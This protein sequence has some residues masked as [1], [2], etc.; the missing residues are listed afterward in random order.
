MEAIHLANRFDEWLGS[1]NPTDKFFVQISFRSVHKPF[2]ASPDLR[3]ACINNEV[4]NDLG[5]AKTSLEL[6]YGGCVHSI[7]QA[8]GLIRA[9]L[10]ARRPDDYANTMLIFTSDN[11]PEAG[12]KGGAGST[13]GMKGRKLSMFEGLL[14]IP[15][16]M[17]WPSVIRQN[18]K[19]GGL[20]SIMD[21][22]QTFS[23]ALRRVSGEKDINI[24]DGVDLFPLLTQNPDAPRPKP[25]GIC[26]CT[27]DENLRR[28]KTLCESMA[29]FDDDGQYKLIARRENP[30]RVGGLPSKAIPQ[31]LYDVTDPI[32]G[33]SNNLKG[34]MPDYVRNMKS[35]TNKWLV[36]VFQ[37]FR[38]NCAEY[39][40]DKKR[41]K[42]PKKKRVRRVLRARRKL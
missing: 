2:V 3:Q 30:S 24:R 15:A 39:Y 29:M 19:I 28:S 36:N 35:R 6:D 13:M 4:C 9:S 7:D 21:F 27:N 26:S 20:A 14:R 25:L 23:E 17:E 22:S 41:K 34:D 1:L 8:V 38:L 5:R 18:K 11:G 37:S 31:F 16:V 12:K 10:R 42:T 40:P 33:E 32:N